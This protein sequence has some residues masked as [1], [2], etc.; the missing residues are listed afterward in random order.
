MVLKTDFG[1]RLGQMLGLG[2][3]DV[4]VRVWNLGKEHTSSF[5]LLNSLDIGIYNCGL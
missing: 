5:N 1:L 3:R 2:N 4:R